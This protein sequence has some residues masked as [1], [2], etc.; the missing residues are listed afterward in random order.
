[1][2]KV[3]SGR[4]ERRKCFDCEQV[5]HIARNC[6]KRGQNGSGEGGSKQRRHVDGNQKSPSREE[7][8]RGNSYAPF[9]YST[10][11][12]VMVLDSGASNH[13]VK[14]KNWLSSV[15]AIHPY[16]VLLGNGSIVTAR[17]RG[18][19]HVQSNRTVSDRFPVIL[20]NVLYIPDLKTNLI[21]CSAPSKDRFEMS[22]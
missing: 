3:F 22:F 20:R 4:I 19:L 10:T 13:M 15:V 17:E 12:F 11:Q 5:G 14:S 6:P 9:K 18:T 21:S 2:R 1:M 7:Q 8:W 16:D